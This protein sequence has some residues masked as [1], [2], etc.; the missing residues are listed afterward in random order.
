MKSVTAINVSLS[1]ILQINP[2]DP[3]LA[4]TFAVKNI[5]LNKVLTLIIKNA[6]TSNA[7]MLL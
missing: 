6:L 5:T 7:N 3:F 2:Q 1:I 4:V